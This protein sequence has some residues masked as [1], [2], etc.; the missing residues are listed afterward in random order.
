MERLTKIVVVVLTLFSSRFAQAKPRALDR[1]VANVDGQA[2]F[3]SDLSS[4]VRPYLKQLDDRH[5]PAAGREA[6][7]DQLLRDLMETMVE[8]YLFEIEAR[9]LELLPTEK[10]IDRAEISVAQDRHS[11]VE[12]VYA[13]A[14]EAGY[15]NAS[16]RA[17]LRRELIELNV[18]ERVLRG[19]L[20]KGLSPAARAAALS[21]ERAALL[22]KLREATYVDTRL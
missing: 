11:S 12:A 2:I 4:R 6:A 9:R 19:R 18:S 8:E 14:R 20:E 17:S 21:R 5:T 15:D 3:F 1:V 22:S 16:Y 13:A 7:E 10:D